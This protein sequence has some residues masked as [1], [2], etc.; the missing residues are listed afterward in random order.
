VTAVD[1]LRERRARHRQ[2]SLLVRIGTALAG[3]AAICGGALLLVLPGP[4]IPLIVVGLGLLALE[5]RWAERPLAVALKHAERVTPKKRTHRVAMGVAV[6]AA[7]AASLT[8]ALLLG[9]PGF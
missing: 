2:R 5:F 3:T 4:G 9:V 7:L 6:V 8:V 1:R